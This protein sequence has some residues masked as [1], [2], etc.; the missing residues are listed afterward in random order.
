MKVRGISLLVRVALLLVVAVVVGHV[1]AMTLMFE[2]RPRLPVIGP[3]GPPPVGPPPVTLWMQLGMV[4]DLGVRLAA[5]G[6]AAWVAVRWLLA[7]MKR[8]ACAARALGDDIEGPPLPEDGTRECQEVSRLFNQMQTRIRQQWS[9]RDRFVAAVSHDLRTPLT[10]LRLRTEGLADSEQKRQFSRDIAEMDDMIR[11]TLDYLCGAAD[12]EATVRLD[13]AALVGSL[14]EDQ[15]E[16]GHQVTVWGTAAPLPA[17]A[18]ALRRCIGNLVENA[19]RYGTSVEIH[20][21]DGAEAVEVSVR[22]RGPGLPEAEL[23][24][25]MAPF[26]RVASSRERHRAG[27]GLG[28]SIAQDIARRHGG[29]LALKNRGDGSGTGL[30]ATLRLPRAGLSR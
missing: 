11:T 4:L 24:K 17:Q 28:L 15:R 1:L 19:I 13:L 18:L 20:L 5:L 26:Y 7:P 12:A 10:R 30:V 21:V 8:L 3:P 23:D 22:D 6:L 27:V 25:V 2:L 9:A 29:E 14:A 16:A